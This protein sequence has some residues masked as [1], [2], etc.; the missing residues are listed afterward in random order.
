MALSI[1]RSAIKTTTI[2]IFTVR[3]KKKNLHQKILCTPPLLT[4]PNE[5]TLKLPEEIVQVFD[6]LNYEIHPN[7]LL[8]GLSYSNGIQIWLFL[9]Y[10]FKL[11]K[12]STV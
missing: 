3:K 8:K 1:N 9:L 5:N 12:D 10:K 11:K 4:E 7:N 2:C 6:S